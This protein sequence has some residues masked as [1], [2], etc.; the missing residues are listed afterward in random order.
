MLLKEKIHINQVTMPGRLF[1]PPVGSY[2]AEE[3]GTVT[4]ELVQHY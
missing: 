4:V 1:M 3:D 2:K